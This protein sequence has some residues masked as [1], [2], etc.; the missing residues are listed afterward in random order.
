MANV[1]TCVV[2]SQ[3]EGDTNYQSYTGPIAAYS[4]LNTVRPANICVEADWWLRVAA[5]ATALRGQRAKREGCH[6]S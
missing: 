3:E 1:H 6:I 2:A 4:D 5:G